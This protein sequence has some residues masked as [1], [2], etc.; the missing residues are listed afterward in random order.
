MDRDEDRTPLQ[1]PDDALRALR[2][3]LNNAS[4]GQLMVD[5]LIVKVSDEPVP[6][7]EAAPVSQER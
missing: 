1:S 2:Q 7:V 3:W 5:S 6:R 4:G